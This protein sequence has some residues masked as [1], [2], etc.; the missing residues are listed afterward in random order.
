MGAVGK[1]K[2]EHGLT[3]ERGT[4]ASGLQAMK[5]RTQAMEGRTHAM[6]GRTHAMEGETHVVR[7]SIVSQTRTQPCVKPITVSALTHVA[8]LNPF[9]R[10]RAEGTRRRRSVSATVN[11]ANGAT[12]VT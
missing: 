11:A 4:R 7:M 12:H 2:G 6:E 3:Q 10:K 5:G 1:R 9:E 8:E